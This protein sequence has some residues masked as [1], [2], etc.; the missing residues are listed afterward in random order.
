MPDKPFFMYFAPG[1]CHASQAWIEKYKGKFDQ[2]WDKLR[3]EIFE[4]QKSLGIET[5]E[6]LLSKI[7]E[8]G[9]PKAYNHSAVGC[10]HAMGT[11]YQWTKQVASHWGGHATGTIVHW[12]NGINAKGA[13]RSMTSRPRTGTTRSTSRCSATAASITRDGP[14]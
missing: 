8:F 11:P 12:P 1:A 10:A 13:M 7:D 9:G 2:G 14:R 6:F 3:E 4:R 5:T